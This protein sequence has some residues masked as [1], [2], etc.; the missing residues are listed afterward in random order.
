[1]NETLHLMNVKETAKFLGITPQTVYAWRRQNKLPYLQLGKRYIF[2]LH[3]LLHF[4]DSQ[5][6]AVQL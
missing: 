6:V 3:D 2:N 5:K 4:L 1:M